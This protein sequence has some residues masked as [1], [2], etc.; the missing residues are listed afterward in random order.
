MKRFNSL[1]LV[2]LMCVMTWIS[3][4]TGVTKL[5][6]LLGLLLG[7][8]DPGDV[9]IAQEIRLPRVLAAILVGASLGIA[10]ALSQG[11]LRNPLAEPILLGTTGGAA[12]ASVLGILF[13]NF[14]LG[15][16]VAVA[17]GVMGALL[18]TLFTYQM[19]KFGSNGLAFVVMGIAVSTAL[20]SLVGITAVM[21][22]KPEARGVSFWALGTLSMTVKSQLLL[23]SPILILSWVLAV[24]IAPDLDYLA[25][26]DLR[27]RHLG[28]N[29]N[30]IRFNVFV[31]IA[32][33]IGV[34][35]SIFGQISFI[36]LAIPH[37]VRVMFGPK[38]RSLIVNS[39]ILGATLLLVADLFARTL[40]KPNE[41]P[42]GLMTALL[43]A[44]LLILVVRKAQSQHA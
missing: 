43:G 32:L 29:A 10:G 1:F 33:A 5:N 36:A 15:S 18:A 37:I 14:S 30:Q 25:L 42:I 12:L 16:P 8:G 38:H 23:I 20:T 28:K 26:G 34:I 21:I 9:Y 39:G 22:N 44:P 2:L 19:G 24:A 3:L 41:L 6:N 17:F 13:F 11:V 40:A 7:N 27:A 35:T 4:N 31:I